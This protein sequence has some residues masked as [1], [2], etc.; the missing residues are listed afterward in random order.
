[1]WTLKLEELNRRINPIVWSPSR[2]A[3]IS[4]CGYK[5]YLSHTI[6]VPRRGS[7]WFVGGRAFAGMKQDVENMMANEEYPAAHWPSERDAEN[8]F[9]R[10]FV[11]EVEKTAARDGDPAEWRAAAQGREDASWWIERG[12]EMARLYIERNP[13]TRPFTTLVMPDGNLGLEV[14]FEGAL[15][16]HLVRGFIDHVTLDSQGYVDIVDDKTGKVP[17]DPFQLDLY[18][19]AWEALYGN[20]VARTNYYLARPIGPRAARQEHTITR[21]WEPE[22]ADAVISRLD[23]VA[24]HE[25]TGAFIPVVSNLCK[26]CDVRASCEYGGTK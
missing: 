21:P 18:A 4:S 12:Q 23:R 6:D 11:R 24:A 15:G 22:R 13:P 10:N 2:V 16:P 8:A 7:W 25:A 5:Y 26:S 19:A 17:E 14:P 20:R 3:S 1:V 9:V